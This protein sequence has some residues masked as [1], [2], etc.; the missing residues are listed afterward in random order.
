[1]KLLTGIC[2]VRGFFKDRL[3]K[4]SIV[5]ECKD[6]DK[7]KAKQKEEQL[8]SALSSAMPPQC[9][10]PYYQPPVQLQFN[11]LNQPNVPFSNPLLKS[12]PYSE[13]QKYP[14]FEKEKKPKDSHPES[15]K[16]IENRDEG[17][18]EE[19]DENK[20]AE[21]EEGDENK[22][23]E[24]DEEGDEN[25]R[26]EEDEEGD[27]SKKEDAEGSQKYLTPSKKKRKKKKKKKSEDDST[28]ESSTVEGGDEANR[29]KSCIFSLY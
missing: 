21:D 5:L 22:K 9:S 28:V 14:E 10:Y 1:M 16:F 27:Q 25:K 2:L 13:E 24:G 19:G 26:A 3:K 20:R 15:E 29:Y 23:A 8:S 11:P 12:A 17:D 7:D 6:K 18:V 4:Y